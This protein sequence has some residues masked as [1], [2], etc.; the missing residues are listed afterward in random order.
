MAFSAVVTKV[1]TRCCR[2]TL[3]GNGGLPLPRG[4]SLE[5]DLDFGIVLIFEAGQ[6][7]DYS[8]R[9]ELILPVK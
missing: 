9:S 4:V 3:S 6:L 8:L 2:E 7:S 5:L 1:T